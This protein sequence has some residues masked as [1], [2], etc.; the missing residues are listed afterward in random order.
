MTLPTT[1]HG[2]SHTSLI[3]TPVVPAI[4]RDN[5]GSTVLL[6]LAIN[7]EY[8][9][10]YNNYNYYGCF[11][12]NLHIIRALIIIIIRYNFSIRYKYI[13]SMSSSTI[14]LHNTGTYK[15]QSTCTI[16]VQFTVNQL[17][18]QFLKGTRF[19]RPDGC[20]PMNVLVEKSFDFIQAIWTVHCACT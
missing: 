18:Y 5:R 16:V 10:C 20:T 9:L 19:C 4:Q 13:I 11:L 1:L 2:T 17:C 12:T 7:N 15:H 6:L 14:G 3:W 8:F